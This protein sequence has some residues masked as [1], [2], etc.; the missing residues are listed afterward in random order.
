MWVEVFSRTLLALE[1]AE[2]VQEFNRL[3]LVLDAHHQ[4]PRVDE[5]QA[6]VSSSGVIHEQDRLDS[7]VAEIFPR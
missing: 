4:S 7:R 6:A 3:M 2:I 5:R 1:E